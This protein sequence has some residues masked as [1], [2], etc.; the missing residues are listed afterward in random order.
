VA[1]GRFASWQRVDGM[2]GV[3]DRLRLRLIGQG[4]GMP[5][6][7]PEAPDGWHTIDMTVSVANN[8]HW[9]YT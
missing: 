7:T 3:P 5:V 9:P 2:P 4:D 6:V 1:G 8:P